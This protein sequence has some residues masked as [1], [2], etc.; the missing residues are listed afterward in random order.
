MNSILA[1]ALGQPKDK[2]AGLMQAAFSSLVEKHVLFY[3]LD[4]KVESA[5]SDFGVGGKN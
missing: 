1:N 2:L 3:L 4:P 5:V